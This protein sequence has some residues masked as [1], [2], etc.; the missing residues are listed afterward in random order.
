MNRNEVLDRGVAAA[1]ELAAS[2]PWSS[3]SLREIA[4]AAGLAL[5]DFQGLADRDRLALHAD[6]WFDR[7][8]S[9]ETIDPDE[10][11]RERLFDVIMLRFEAMEAHREGVLSLLRAIDRAPVLRLQRLKT[12]RASAEW[13]LISAGLDGAGRMPVAVKAIG[14]GWVIA[15]T[16]EAWRRETDPGFAATMAALDK[17]LRQAEQQMQ[18]MGAFGFGGRSGATTGPAPDAP[19]QDPGD[20]APAG[21]DG[22]RTAPDSPASA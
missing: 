19:T 22:P 9:A 7:A 12:R 15:R 14:L 2:R 5:T 16:E 8:M 4:D 17:G 11:P 1:I 10:P 13:A 3:I 18:R 6:A 21:H 20:S